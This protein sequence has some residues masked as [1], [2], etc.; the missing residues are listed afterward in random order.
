V[1]TDF[2]LLEILSNQRKGKV[3]SKGLQNFKLW[4]NTAQVIPEE[5]DET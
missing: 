4:T 2:W 1:T 3:A 5:T